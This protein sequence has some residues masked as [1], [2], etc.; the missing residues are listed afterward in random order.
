MTPE[1]RLGV[2]RVNRRISRASRSVS[3]VSPS[4]ALPEASRTGEGTRGFLPAFELGAGSL[5]VQPIVPRLRFLQLRFAILDRF[6]VLPQY[7]LPKQ[8][9]TVLAGRIAG[10]RAGTRTTR[11]IRWFAGKYGVDMS[12][13]GNADIASYPT[14]NE[15]FTR[16]LKAGARPIAE[17]DF[18]MAYGLHDQA[19]DLINGALEVEPEREELLA[20]LCEVYF[21]WGNRD[22]FVEAAHKMTAVVGDR[23]SAEWD[24]IVIMGQQIAADHE[25]F[26]GKTAGAATKAVDLSLDAEM[27]LPG[28]LDIDFAILTK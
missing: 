14:F 18:H 17:A 9:L 24:K 13:A 12:E 16:S 4:H 21:V 15:F 19:A 25:L 8:A 20:K 10:A 26:S 11:L 2:S 28:E 27:D 1:L 6:K 22:A 3:R 5:A 23:S 7:L